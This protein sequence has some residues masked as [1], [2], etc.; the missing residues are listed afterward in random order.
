M[1]EPV[2]I[3]APSTASAMALL[4]ALARFGYPD[5]VPVEEDR[6]EVVIADPGRDSLPELLRV[7][8]RWTLVWEATPATV[9]I[10]GVPHSLRADNPPCSETAP[11]AATE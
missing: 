8:E 5:L 11:R 1:Q 6:W 2:R 7:V 3:E 9:T 4:A 10:D